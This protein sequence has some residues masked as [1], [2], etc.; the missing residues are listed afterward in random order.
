MTSRG[1][2]PKQ[3]QTPYGDPPLYLRN[4]SLIEKLSFYGSYHAN[5]VYVNKHILFLIDFITNEF[6]VINHAGIF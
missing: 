1:I 2:T 5:L 6:I 3:I 4:K